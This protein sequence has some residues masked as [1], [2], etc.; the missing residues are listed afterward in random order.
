L[1]KSKFRKFAINRLKKVS[2]NK[3]SADKKAAENMSFLLDKIAKKGDKILLYIPMNTEVNTLPYINKKRYFY[4]IFVPFMEGVSFK[5]VRFR[6]PLSVRKY[7]IRETK[8]SNSYI[9]DL[10]FMVVP[11]IGVDG[12]YQRVGFGKGM[13]DRFFE[14]LSTK[15]KIIF[16][17]LDKIFTNDYICDSYDI[18]ADYYITPKD[19]L[20]I[21]VNRYGRDRSRRLISCC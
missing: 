19:I 5:M 12:N 11:V 8:N 14:K 18:K 13:Y 15:P 16:I 6:Y 17:Q 20:E 3:Y 1:D 4:N 7:G 9:K 10:D 2:K 21:K